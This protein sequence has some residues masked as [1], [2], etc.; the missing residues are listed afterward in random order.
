MHSSFTLESKIAFYTK[1]WTRR[2]CRI[3]LILHILELDKVMATAAETI[4]KP[5]NSTLISDPN[6][7]QY[8]NASTITDEIDRHEQTAELSYYS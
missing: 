6:A 4:V 1:D 7:M 5:K 3:F 8:R 2:F